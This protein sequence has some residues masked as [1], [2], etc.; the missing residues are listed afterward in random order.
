[1]NLHLLN[2]NVTN[3]FKRT[4]NSTYSRQ[5]QIDTSSNEANSKLN[6]DVV[7]TVGLECNCWIYWRNQTNRIENYKKN[8]KRN[9]SFELCSNYSKKENGRFFTHFY[10]IPRHRQCR[11]SELLSMLS[12]NGWHRHNDCTKLHVHNNEQLFRFGFVQF[13]KFNS[14]FHWVINIW[15]VREYYLEFIISRRFSS[16][17]SQAFACLFFKFFFCYLSRKTHF[18]CNFPVTGF[19]LQWC[20]HRVQNIFNNPQWIMM[21]SKRF[22]TFARSVPT[23]DRST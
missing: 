18:V 21:K 7:V 3:E 13:N 6:R 12:Q 19:H 5:F 15:L 4:V 22:S 20:P 8:A 23:F 9:E 2:N 10:Q 1:M 16:G 17:I 14:I 11:F